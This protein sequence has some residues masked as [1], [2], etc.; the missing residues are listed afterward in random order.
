MRSAIA[1]NKRVDTRTPSDLKLPRK[2]IWSGARRTGV[3]PLV[4]GRVRKR[5]PALLFWVSD[6]GCFNLAVIW[7]SLIIWYSFCMFSYN[8]MV[9]EL[10]LLAQSTWIILSVWWAGLWNPTDQFLVQYVSVSW[11]MR[12]NNWL[13]ILHVFLPSEK[14]SGVLKYKN[15]QYKTGDYVYINSDAYPMPSRSTLI[16]LHNKLIDNI[17]DLSLTNIYSYS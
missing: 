17:S 10:I 11:L 6:S 7:K 2:I 8:H 1:P 16:I 15:V 14:E 13:Y 12:V 4:L 5:A 3:V 9:Q